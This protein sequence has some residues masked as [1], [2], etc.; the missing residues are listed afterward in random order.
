MKK[1]IITLL[2]FCAVVSYWLFGSTCTT[3]AQ[4][5]PLIYGKLTLA[6]DDGYEAVYTTV[7]PILAANNLFG[8]AFITTDYLGTEKYMIWDQVLSL[9]N[10]Y[11]WEINPHSVTHPDL[12]ELTVA[13]MQQEIYGSIEELHSHGIYPVN[14]F[15]SPFGS[16]DNVTLAEIS[17]AVPYH[18][19]FWELTSFN[20]V[21]YNSTVLV[22]KSVEEGVTPA[23]VNQWISEALNNKTWL[24]LV[25]HDVLPEPQESDPYVTTIN[26]FTEIVDN[27][28]ASG[29][30]INSFGQ[31]FSY[32]QNNLVPNGSI[33]QSPFNTGWTTDQ[34]TSVT[35]NTDNNGKF[36]TAQSCVMFQG[37]DT[38]PAHL[39]S[40]SIFLNPLG[41]YALSTF[42]NTDLLSQGELGFYIDEYDTDGNWISGQWLGKVLL[43]S[44]TTF[45]SLYTPTSTAVHQIKVQMYLTL[46]S[47]GSVYADS[48]SLYALGENPEPTPT[49]TPSPT[50]TPTPGP[51]DELV[52]NG[53][54]TETQPDG[55]A[56][57][58]LRD[59]TTVVVAPHPVTG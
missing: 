36:P 37:A 30:S 59:N 41:T 6:F 34:P 55:W 58:W 9:Q 51:T 35:Y 10:D 48:F 54:F 17:K 44:V 26:D 14:T 3:F 27:I 38:N 11:G 1:L 50:P 42:V 46:G 18:R 33:D 23:Q 16:Y 47:Q 31:A 56:L 24:I 32:A 20:A 22:V 43:N 8:T 29:I 49:P 53:T 4:E 28:V 52:L 12:I 15:A 7:A 25:F 21:P 57:N 39:F 5:L 40:P 45:T 19:S 13:E 2:V